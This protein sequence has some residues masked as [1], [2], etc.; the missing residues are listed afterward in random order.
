MNLEKLF[1]R[2]ILVLALLS[3]VLNLS[4]VLSRMQDE[5]RGVINY[6]DDF[7]RVEGRF[8]RVEAGITNSTIDVC[9]QWGGQ[10]LTDQNKLI[11]RD[12]EIPL[13]DGLFAKGQ[14]IMCIKQLQDD[15]T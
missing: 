6:S 10:W 4:L 9:F 11:T 2:A 8:D 14:A 12:F 7:N 1:L 13:E 15:I 3:F 5:S